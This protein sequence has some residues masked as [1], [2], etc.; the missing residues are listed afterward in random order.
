VDLPVSPPNRR[1]WRGSRIR[2]SLRGLM[3]LVLLLGIWMGWYVRRVKLQRDAVAAI[4]RA[5]GTVAY[6]WEWSHYNPDIIDLNGKPRAPKWLSDRVGVDYV[7][8]VVHVNL[9][10]RRVSAPNRA[11]DKTLAH[12]GRLGHLESLWLNGTAI[13]DVGLAHIKDLTGLRGLSLGNTLIGDPG[14]AHLEGM[15]RLGTLDLVGSRVTD[16]GVLKLERALPGLRV[17]R[18]EDIA[19]SPNI[20]RAI[21]DL[22]FARSQPIRLASPLLAHRAMVM[23]TE[24][25]EA[26]LIATV[27]AICGLQA[28][29]KVGL[30][31]VAEAC[32]GCIGMLEQ[33]TFTPKLSTSE[34]QSLRRRCVDRGIA[35][36]ALAIDQG[37][38]NVRRLDGDFRESFPLSNLREHPSFPKLIERMRAIRPGR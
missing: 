9:V 28:N 13:T 18:E 14:L 6:D 23:T 8:N 5:G 38:N 20:P 11:D 36:L 7:G 26:G 31:K 17:S 21:K 34:R 15:E 22:N 35:A 25:D 24:R 4:K 29:D 19:V 12:V 32:A 30:L 2:L 33:P 27:D 3:A 1:W 10:P 16:E 37:Y